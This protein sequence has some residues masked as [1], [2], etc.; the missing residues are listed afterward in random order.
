MLLSN[1]NNLH[2]DL[3]AFALKESTWDNSFVQLVTK[4]KISVS[5]ISFDGN[6]LNTTTTFLNALN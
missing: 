1:L 2:G 4:D 6:I 3:T 5:S